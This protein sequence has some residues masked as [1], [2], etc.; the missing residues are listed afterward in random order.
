MR[1][2]N[3]SRVWVLAGLMLAQP[4]LAQELLDSE[5]QDSRTENFKTV[6]SLEI[7]ESDLT[8]TPAISD[9]P[10]PADTTFASPAS[11]API[12]DEGPLPP[13]PVS[14]YSR[15]Q[16][17]AKGGRYKI[18]HPGAAQGLIRIDKE[19]YQ[20]KVPLKEKSQ[21]ASFRFA[22]IS[23]PNI[24]SDQGISFSSYYGGGGLSG[25]LGEYEWMPFKG[26]GA[27]GVQLGGGL[28]VARG[29]GRFVGGQTANEVYTLFVVPISV[30]AIYRF[31][32]FRR[33]W[34][35]PFI[36]GGGTYFGLAEKRDDAKPATFAG[37]PAAAFG[38]GL[39]IGISR[40]DLRSAFI[41]SRDY[42]VSDVWFTIEG[43]VIAGLRKDLDFSSQAISAGFTIDY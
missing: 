23:T 6:P 15:P 40:W 38:G 7:P 1:K 5:M 8:L 16:G 35:V 2:K 13:P 32:Y 4:V 34:V 42:G 20:Y 10:Q 39:H 27:L 18:E 22:G 14:N 17:P 26:F 21:A 3:A 33:Q 31:E 29:N 25:L 19:G 43:R 30:L 37:S 24:T 36:N 11:P 12:L 28:V 41:L 9:V